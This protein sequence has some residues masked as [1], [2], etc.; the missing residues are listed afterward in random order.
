MW[1]PDSVCNATLVEC[2]CVVQLA[3][4]FS[5]MVILEREILCIKIAF[6]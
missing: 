6:N 3:N 1:K 4:E 2:R 5:L